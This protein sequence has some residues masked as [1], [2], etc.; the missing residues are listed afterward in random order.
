MRADEHCDELFC[1]EDRLGVV[2]GLVGSQLCS[3]EL[4]EGVEAA[5]EDTEQAPL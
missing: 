5:D 3:I 1:D 4:E 2:G